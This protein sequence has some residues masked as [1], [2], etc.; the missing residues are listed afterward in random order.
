M[1]QMNLS[2]RKKQTHRRRADLWLS[3]EEG[4]GEW[5]TGTLGLADAD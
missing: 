4:A 1:T 5:W 3:G 2:M